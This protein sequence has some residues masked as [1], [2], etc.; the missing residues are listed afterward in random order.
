ME[1]GI[2][3]KLAKD[4]AEKV[5]GVKADDFNRNID[6]LSIEDVR[7][8]GKGQPKKLATKKE[9][10]ELVFVNSKISNPMKS[11]MVLQGLDGTTESIYSQFRIE[12]EAIKNGME[13]NLK[14]ILDNNVALGKKDLDNLFYNAKIYNDLTKQVN[15]L[16]DDLVANGK[17]PQQI[18]DD[19]KDT[20]TK[21]ELGFKAE[22]IKKDPMFLESMNK[23]QKLIREMEDIKSG[24]AEIDRKAL[25]KRKYQGKGYGPSEGIYRTLARQ[26]LRD[27]IEAGRIET[28]Q[29]I[30]NAIKEGGHPFIDPIK[31]FRHHYG[32][33]A[34]DTLEKY[35]DNNYPA[36]GSPGIRY[37]GRF[38]FRKLGLVPK[39]KKAPGKTY[40]HYNLPDEI[41]AEI[42]SIDN[43][44]SDIELGKSPMVRNKQ[45]LLEAIRTQNEKRAQ[46]VKIRNEIAPE[47]TKV[48]PGD[49]LLETAEV[50]PIKKEGIIS[51]VDLNID[52]GIKKLEG[53]ELYGDETSD[54]LKYIK[55]N[56]VHPRD[57]DPREGFARGGIVEV[58][59]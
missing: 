31:V 51:N 17:N 30:Y 33:D 47:D 19:Y 56:G 23:I 58:L 53:V 39:N 40:A 43:L 44:I 20:F 8:K 24:K 15:K 6:D 49:D 37:P 9:R 11:K 55:E 12:L 2:P 41:D 14:Y 45:E 46:Y 4:L 3:E 10:G 50:V 48:Q 57:L 25:V 52:R 1:N 21:K 18:F 27:E 26:F 35:I 42:E 16:S 34:F 22:D 29:N 38:E 36:F 5:S 7:I 13:K 28:T 59:I 32:D 54:E